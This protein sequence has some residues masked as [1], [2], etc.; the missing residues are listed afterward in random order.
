MSISR[1]ARV[2]PFALLAALAAA[3]TAIVPARADTGCSGL[4]HIEYTGPPLNVNQIQ[5]PPATT[6][7]DVVIGV[8][9]EVVIDHDTC[10]FIEGPIE[11]VTW[12]NI[13]EFDETYDKATHQNRIDWAY[14]GVPPPGTTPLSDVPLVPAASSP[15]KA[16]QTDSKS[17]LTRH[18]VTMRDVVGIALVLVNAEY[19]F[20]NSASTKMVES[21]SARNHDA[22]VSDFNPFHNW[23]LMG[24]TFGTSCQFGGPCIPTGHYWETSY[25]FFRGLFPPV[26]P[27]TFDQRI[28]SVADSFGEGERPC[29][30]RIQFSL[31]G[32]LG[33]LIPAGS[34]GRLHLCHRV[35]P[36]S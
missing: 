12:G 11:T 14:Y 25:G 17:F 20:A 1:L 5:I 24:K 9:Q 16:E 21:V 7:D 8:N 6:A 10:T 28:W 35:I 18:K 19:D 31:D 33:Q 13:S 36:L 34:L 2:G 22:F 26:V 30:S 3:G 4:T 15:M 23:T 27:A 29:D 32:N